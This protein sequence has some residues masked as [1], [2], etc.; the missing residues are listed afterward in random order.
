MCLSSVMMHA[1]RSQMEG[2]ASSAAAPAPSGPGSG[3]RIANLRIAW[4]Y[5]LVVAFATGMDRVA[6]GRHV[7]DVAALVSATDDDAAVRALLLDRR[8]VLV[9]G[10]H[11]T[12]FISG[13]IE[14]FL[15]FRTD[16][17]TRASAHGVCGDCK[18]Q[19][20]A[21]QVPTGRSPYVRSILCVVATGSKPNCIAAG[22]A[23]A[24][25]PLGSGIVLH[26]CRM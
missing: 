6:R 11:V 8:I 2:G 12:S 26:T 7:F 16:V 14:L 9:R 4:L 10:R 19:Y 20:G 1:T 24:Y 13:T 22:I 21:V 25:R 15:P 23:L 3:R 5:F 17:R 18:P